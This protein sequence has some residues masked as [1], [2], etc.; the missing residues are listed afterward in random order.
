VVATLLGEGRG[1][2]EARCSYGGEIGLVIEGG[3]AERLMMGT[4]HF[5]VEHRK[6]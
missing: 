1:V 6:G 5:V 2:V 3:E 4:V